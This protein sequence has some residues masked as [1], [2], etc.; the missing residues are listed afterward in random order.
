MSTSPSIHGSP[1]LRNGST[2]PRT[3]PH[4][5]RRFDPRWW[6]ICC[7]GGLLTYGL[8][9]LHFDTPII[10][11]VATIGTALAAQWLFTLLFRIPTFEWKSALISGFGLCFLFRANDW[12]L[13]VLCAALAIGSK[14]LIRFQG[15]HLWNPTNFALVAMM[16]AFDQAWVSP[17]QWGSGLTLAYAMACAGAFVVNRSARSDTTVAFLAAYAVVLFGRSLWVSEP[18]TIAAH[19]MTSGAL[20]IFAFHMISDPKTTPNTRAGR[21]LFASMV[22]VGAGFVAFKLFRPNGPIWALAALSPLVP[23]IDRVLPGPKYE[24]KRPVVGPL[25]KG[26]LHEPMDSRVR[27]RVGGR[28]LGAGRV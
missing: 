9:R 1:A 2:G 19:R 28:A 24:W 25:W 11:I 8:L 18:L 6:Q 4:P 12:R 7:L 17:G 26:D 16:L 27:D 14:F 22:A 15:K 13:A 3:G 21:I 23:L 10:Q 5:G 20:M